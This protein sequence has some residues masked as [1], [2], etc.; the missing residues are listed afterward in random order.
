MTAVVK[1]F[2]VAC[3]FVVAVLTALAAPTTAQNRSDC[4]V[5]QLPREEVG[6]NRLAVRI[7]SNWQ[8]F[9]PN[10]DAPAHVIDTS[11]LHDDLCLAWEAPPYQRRKR[12]IVYAGTQYRTDQPLY[13][14]RNSAAAGIPFFGR[15]FGKWGRDQ[16]E[17]NANPSEDFREFHR[18]LPDDPRSARWNKL[19][20]WHNTSAWFANRP[21]YELVSAT[22][23]RTLLPQ[24]TERLLVLAAQRPFTSWVKIETM[25]PSGQDELRVAISFSGDLGS[26]EP[27]VHK[28]VFKTR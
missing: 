27:R 23:K 16:D 24:G 20:A 3:S 10:D 9:A 14:M 6:Q 12:Q 25:V 28:Y 1:R 13:L 4:N 2:V 5:G 26:R 7:D 22:S 21:S 15:L 18:S 11:G 19:A 17:S 8:F